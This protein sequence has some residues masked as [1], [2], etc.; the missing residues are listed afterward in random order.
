MAA[1]DMSSMVAGALS[2]CVAPWREEGGGRPHPKYDILFDGEKLAAAVSHEE[3]DADSRAAG[4][5]GPDVKTAAAIKI[6]EGW[7][8]HE[9]TS[10]A[11]HT[12]SPEGTGRFPAKGFIRGRMCDLAIL[13]RATTSGANP[14]TTGMVSR[15]VKKAAQS[16]EDDTAYTP[17]S[18][19]MTALLWLDGLL[20]LRRAGIS[21]PDT[22][23]I[24]AE[25]R[26]MMR[27]GGAPVFGP[28]VDALERM[29]DQAAGPMAHIQ[30]AA[31]LVSDGG[32]YRAAATGADLLPRLS[33]DRQRAAEFYTR[34]AVAELLAG[35]VISE[36][37]IPDWSDGAIFQRYR[38]AD[39]AC[40][41]GTLLRAGF[42]R[43]RNL[44]EAGGGTIST[45]AGLHRDAVR[46]GISGVDVYPAAAHMALSSLA[47]VMPHV[48]DGESSM[49]WMGVGG[50]K[51]YTGSIELVAADSAPDPR[52]GGR[53]ATDSGR[54]TPVS[55]PDRSCDWIIMN[56]PYSRTRIGRA[57]FDIAGLSA[58]DR[59]VC[60]K[61][62][63]R[64][65]QEEPARKTAGMAATYVVIAGK[66]IK[67]GGR[68]GFVLPGSA[69][70]V[71][72]W[73]DTRNHI[74][75]NYTDIAAV[76]FAGRR[77]GD[78]LSEDTSIA[79]ML[80]VA[81]RLEKPRR[82]PSP[83]YCATI[84]GYPAGMGEAAETARAISS[85][86]GRAKESGVRTQDVIAGEAIGKIYAFT[87][88]RGG[89]PWSP[90]GV[91]SAE[92]ARTATHAAAGD[93]CFLDGRQ[94][95]FAVRMSPMEKVF[96][97]GPTHHII[98]HRP[99]RMQLGAFE[100]ID[101]RGPDM[102]MWTAATKKQDGL[103]M[104]PTHT[105]KA[106][107]GSDADRE[108]MRGWSGTLFYTRRIGWKGQ[109]L[110]AATTRAPSMG[111]NAWTAL[112]HRDVRVLRAAALWFN[113][114][115]GM[116]VHWT[117]GQRTQ[118]ARSN[119]EMHALKAIP[120]PRFA[121]L[122]QDTLDAAAVS[123]ESLSGRT[124]MPA[125]RA[126]ADPVRQEMDGAVCTMLGL[127]DGAPAE[128][129]AIRKLFC[130]EP[131]VTGK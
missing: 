50:P 89:A 61:R 100:I 99:G 62:W 6:G 82:T 8:R 127:P 126:D 123:F 55:I 113:S 48:W 41:T 66:K 60:Q 7:Q 84:H 1:P 58:A 63:G 104:E 49:G 102:F 31:D 93:F 23:A 86:L 122:P 10:Y 47:A 78:S 91:V 24:V 85:A 42:G 70:F 71:E 74:V 83:V 112:L 67:A 116:M 72:A 53:V 19:L 97:I 18:P 32:Q 56:P 108:R 65:M 54:N 76:A 88:D 130:Q 34:A 12:M 96:G 35:L 101:G 103:I 105:G 20:A 124:L 22:H 106:G 9:H 14:E 57:A 28:A 92:L 87:P 51:G 2:E 13:L 73:S 117:Q 45:T 40:G 38:L 125:G 95:R 44:H 79:E 29:G 77:K 80:L 4:Y 17:E 98:G 115:L 25:W 107:T 81:Q 114:T 43:I 118:A 5:L 110:L 52:M 120:C 119:T 129:D 36:D 68:I 37:D 21:D 69:A 111:G 27:D 94:V 33:A 75:H 26:R 90:L 16:M 46:R 11:I 131:S 30:R 121:D 15:L 3:D 109:R 59:A 128:L 39:L 64:L